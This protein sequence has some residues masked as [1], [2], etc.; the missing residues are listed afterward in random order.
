[1]KFSRY[2][3][4]IIFGFVAGVSSF[5]V[6][7]QNCNANIVSS[8]PSSRFHDNRDGSVTD[9]DT[10]LRWSRCSLGQTWERDHC[11]G[12]ARALPFA[13]ASLLAE[14]GWRLPSV[15]EI[16]SLVEL[17]CYSPAINT[18]IFPTPASGIYWTNTRFIN[19]DGSFWQLHSLHGETVPEKADSLALVRWVKRN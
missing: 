3:F 16:T 2:F 12:E 7:A 8:S 4:I 17:R 14:K 13:T 10:G 5:S 11:M 15:S 9:K 1:M 19:R 6:M 18:E